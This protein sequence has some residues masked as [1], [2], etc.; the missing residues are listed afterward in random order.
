ME[1]KLKDETKIY[2]RISLVPIPT[3]FLS[4]TLPSAVDTDL[5]GAVGQG[6]RGMNYS[7]K[8]KQNSLYHSV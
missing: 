4:I 2:T 1:Y 6:G 8:Y 7:I 5:G 3:F